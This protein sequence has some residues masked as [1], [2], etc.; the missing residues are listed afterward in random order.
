[1]PWRVGLG[2]AAG[3]LSQKSWER[4]KQRCKYSHRRLPAAFLRAGS[5]SRACC[6][7]W[8]TPC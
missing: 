4:S 8:L 1:M 3:K 2:S 7:L 5:R 6:S